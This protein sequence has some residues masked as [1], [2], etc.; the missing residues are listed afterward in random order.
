MFAYVVVCS[1]L[2]T[3][4][5][6]ATPVRNLIEEPS[7]ETG[8]LALPN[9]Q[10]PRIVR[11]DLSVP[12]WVVALVLIG[13]LVGATLLYY[14]RWPWARAKTTDLRLVDAIYQDAT[15][16]SHTSVEPIARAPLE[17][18]ILFSKA[19]A[20]QLVLFYGVF[21]ISLAKVWPK[22]LGKVELTVRALPEQK[23]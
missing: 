7:V 22:L 17:A 19:P 6:T 2:P 16:R 20:A 11:E 18:K 21:K 12:A 1:T 13:V 23:V 4:M 15:L 5:D 9:Q 3:N 14:R 8:I 10:W